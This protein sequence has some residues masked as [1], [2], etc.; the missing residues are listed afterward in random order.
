LWSATMPR[1]HST[2][3]TPYDVVSTRVP[4]TVPD[5]VPDPSGTLAGRADSF[6]WE[7]RHNRVTC[8]S[9]RMRTSVTT[10]NAAIHDD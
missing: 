6:C 9:L 1:R 3:A 8:S 4:I 7:S 2:A 10:G 5:S